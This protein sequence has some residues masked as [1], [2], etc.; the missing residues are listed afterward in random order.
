[1]TQ[2]EKCRYSF[3]ERYE[4]RCRKRLM[5]RCRHVGPV[6]KLELVPGLC[7]VLNPAGDCGVFKRRFWVWLCSLLG[8]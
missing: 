6:Q 1:M 4:R 5:Q 3:L 2:C 7:S 8:K